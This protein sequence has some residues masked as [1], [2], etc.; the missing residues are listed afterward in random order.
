MD[1]IIRK[2]IIM[3]VYVDAKTNKVFFS[4][5]HKLKRFYVYTGLQTTEKFGGM[6]FPRSDNNARAK[7]AMLA[8]LYSSCEEYILTH[9]DESVD[10][11]KEHLKELIT[12]AKRIKKNNLAECMLEFSESRNKENTR[13]AYRRTYKCVYNFDKKATLDSID[14]KWMEAF[15][16]HERDRGLKSNGI[17]TEVAHIKA[18]VKK[19]VEDGKLA[20]YPLYSVRVKKEETK[21]RCLSLEQMRAFRDVR[22]YR[23][24]SV[25]YLDCFMLGFYLMGINISDLLTLKKT[26][27]H[28][29][30]LSYYRNKTGRL[31]DI[32]VEPEAMEIINKYKGGKEGRLLSFLDKIKNGSI[33]Y[34]TI[35]LNKTLRRVGER[36]ERD[37]RRACRP[38]EPMA[39][40]Y[41]NRH[42]WATFASEIGIPMEVI[43]RALGHSIWSNSITA[44]Y[45]KYDTKAIDDANRKVIDYLNSDLG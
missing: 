37:K 42:T 15:I 14:K 45:V 32:K 29:G 18:V 38:I 5:T 12:G 11:M 27:L 34:F 8:K 13:L 7:T 31:Y 36:D 23:R 1:G 40:S 39:T 21:K 43:G 30:R 2:E 24:S 33:T 3:K 16:A 19:A 22:T 44:V 4:V 6:V 35:N 26:D 9:F 25:M 28:N 10:D 20:S 17:A 41:Y